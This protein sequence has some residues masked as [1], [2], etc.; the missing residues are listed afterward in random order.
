MTALQQGAFYDPFLVLGYQTAK[1]GTAFVREFLPHAEQV[2]FDGKTEMP[3]T[4]LL[5]ASS[6]RARPSF[7]Q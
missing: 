2:M 4:L 6:W 1:D 3:I 7:I 5:F